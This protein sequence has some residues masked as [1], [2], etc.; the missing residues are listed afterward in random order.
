MTGLLVKIDID[1]QNFPIHQMAG[2]E[3]TIGVV[4]VTSCGYLNPEIQRVV[5]QPYDPY[6][7]KSKSMVRSIYGVRFQVSGSGRMGTWSFTLFSNF[8]ASSAIIL[9]IPGIIVTLIAQNLLGQVSNTVTDATYEPSNYVE[10]SFPLAVKAMLYDRIFRRD[11]SK[12]ITDEGKEA[13][14]YTRQ[15]LKQLIKEATRE[16]QPPVEPEVLDKVV[17]GIFTQ[18]GCKRV[19]TCEQLIDILLKHE[20]CTMREASDVLT[21]SVDAIEWLLLDQS[22]L[23]N[24]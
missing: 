10:S 13:D 15:D 5:L 12:V 24:K 6:T 8:L 17:D 19:M 21:T 7:G 20:P 3:D 23:K 18:T 1:F 14:G 4:K 2:V 16:V 9:T 22:H 11:A